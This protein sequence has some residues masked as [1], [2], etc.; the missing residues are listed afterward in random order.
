VSFDPLFIEEAPLASD[1]EWMLQS[2]QASSMMLAEALLTEFY[3]PVYQMAFAVLGDE[4]QARFVAAETFST[5]LLNIYRYRSQS[6]VRLW[7]FRLEVE[8]LRGLK[9]NQQM[10]AF[11]AR[12]SRSVDKNGASAEGQS[13]E[14][15]ERN[16]PYESLNDDEPSFEMN[17][18]ALDDKARLAA[19]FHCLLDLSSDEIAGCMQTR[20]RNIEMF[21]SDARG[22]LEA[23]LGWEDQGLSGAGWE[24]A[25]D[26][27]MGERLQEWFTI[28]ETIGTDLASL[29]TEAAARA[30]Q[31][32]LFRRKV[33]SFREAVA[34]GA[35]VVLGVLAIWGA[36]RMLPEST[37]PESVHKAVAAAEM[38]PTLSPTPSRPVY[39]LVRSGDSL[40]SIAAS[41]QTSVD[42]LSRLNHLSP[43]A[44]LQPGERLQVVVGDSQEME[45]EAFAAAAVV[46][47][48]AVPKALS[49]QSTSQ[50]IQQ[51]LALSSSLWQTLWFEVQTGFKVGF[52]NPLTVWKY[53][54]LYRVTHLRLTWRQKV[55]LII[56]SLVA[57]RST[58]MRL[59]W[60]AAANYSAALSS[61]RWYSLISRS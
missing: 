2:G 18:K 38:T 39:Y 15:D 13:I 34:I 53:L 29:A 21:L 46:R 59:G 43:S 32:G 44:T 30:N 5:A 45:I 31:R 4:S 9:R 3:S 1:L 55:T 11:F 60:R 50:E 19:S 57:I 56:M 14:L 61:I 10:Q 7:L 41:L 51:R 23:C 24:E 16:D 20:P 42:E 28:S 58:L 25:V 27:L 40:D 49:D 52:S 22:Q 6:G 35:L 8:V 33:F 17:W 26:R 47:S 36:S 37:S 12:T 48:E 54:D